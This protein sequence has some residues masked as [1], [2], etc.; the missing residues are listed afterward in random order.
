MK[1]LKPLLLVSALVLGLGTASAFAQQATA[2]DAGISAKVKAALESDNVLAGTQITVQSENGQVVLKGL[3]TSDSQ[4]AE[5]YR[6]AVSVPGVQKVQNR[7]IV[8][9]PTAA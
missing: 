8:L 3:V 5:A 7:V 6:V 4:Y 2:D 9:Q 1:S